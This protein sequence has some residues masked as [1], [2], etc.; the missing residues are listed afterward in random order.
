MITEFF[1][2]YCGR[3]LAYFWTSALR[4]FNGPVH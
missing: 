4:L 1:F 2:L 3:S